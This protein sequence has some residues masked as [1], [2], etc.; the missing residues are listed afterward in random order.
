MALGAEDHRGRPAPALPFQKWMNNLLLLFSDRGRDSE[1]E[2]C[3][4]P[5]SEAQVQ[6]SSQLQEDRAREHR[7]SQPSLDLAPG[8]S[9]ECVHILSFTGLALSWFHVVDLLN[10]TKDKS[11]SLMYI[12][13]SG[14]LGKLLLC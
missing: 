11:I 2:S 14:S 8:R 1:E 5:S 10:H 12:F 9:W 6:F 3:C 13:A 4:D 7:P